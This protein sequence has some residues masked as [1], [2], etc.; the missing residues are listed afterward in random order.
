MEIDAIERSTL[1]QKDKNAYEVQ[2]NA[3]KEAREKKLA[4]EI[5]KISHDKAVFDKAVS[6]AQIVLNTTLAVTG[7]LA[8]AKTLGI[9]AAPLAIS[10]AAVGA[11]QLAIAAATQI[12][13]YAKGGIHKKEGLALFGEAGSELVKE[14]GS[15]PY[16]AEKP[17]IKH[18]PAGTQL[19]PL[20]NI[21]S[22]SETKNDSWA[23]T[24][25][26][27]KQIAKSKREIKN[28]FKP[29]IVVDLNRQIYINRIL[30]G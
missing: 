29:K 8:Q 28:I 1:S 27:G 20:Y 25:Y 13:E 21:P 26:L 24:M 12:P 22:F 16:I 14:P 23:Q 15:K 4:E 10:Y 3:Q 9:A 2:L 6:M 18:L 17:T 7:A 30:H 19:I 11:V 5:K